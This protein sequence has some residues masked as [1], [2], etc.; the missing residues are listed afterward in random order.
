MTLA[1]GTSYN[2]EGAGGFIKKNTEDTLAFKGA[3]FGGGKNPRAGLQT[4]M[5]GHGFKAVISTNPSLIV[6]TRTI[7]KSDSAGLTGRG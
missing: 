7:S 1:V 6:Q 4:P 5:G 3:G 2:G